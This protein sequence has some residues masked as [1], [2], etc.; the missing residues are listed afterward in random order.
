[1]RVTNDIST[2]ATGP[3]GTRNAAGRAGERE[4]SLHWLHA[5]VWG[6]VL[7]PLLVFVAACWW[8]REQSFND[9]RDTVLRA[10]RVALH[11]A[12]GALETAVAVMQRA[13]READAP[14]A[15]L[16][17]NEREI[18]QHLEDFVL[19]LPAVAA[20]T[21]WDAGGHPV[22]SS[23]VLPVHGKPSIAGRAYFIEHRT[24]YRGLVVTRRMTSLVD[25]RPYIFTS[26]RRTLA[27]GSFGGVVVVALN[28]EYFENFYR[29]LALDDPDLE[30]FS[31]F[32]ADGALLTRWPR[33]DG[34]RMPAGNAL[35]AA[36]R[37]GAR[38]GVLFTRPDG[39]AER[40]LV[41]FHRVGTEPIYVSAGLSETAFLA[42]WYRLVTLLAAVLL[43]I[44]AGLVY[45]S[46]VALRKARRE[47]SVLRQL[48]DENRL[49][50]HAEQALVQTQ[51]LE[52]LA[53]LTGGV[54]HDFNN[55]LAIINTSLHVHKR[56]HPQIGESKQIA[57]IARAVTSGARLTRQLLSFS[58]KQAIRPE[59][60]RLQQWLPA[61]ADLLRTTLGRGIELQVDVSAETP[62]VQI[63]PNEFE[64]AL[65]NIAV[66]AR[67]A[68]PEGGRFEIHAEE[69][70][71]AL[72]GSARMVA[73]HIH[74]T[75]QGIP[76]AVL[77]RVF[78]PFFTTKSPGK[79][80]GLGLSQVYGLCVQAGGMATVE[81]VAGQG[82]T[83]SLLLPAVGATAAV[84]TKT[85]IAVTTAARLHGCVLLIE[86]NGE[87][88]AGL[89]A[90][91]Q[92][93]GLS[94]R[95]AIDAEAGLAM[96][97]KDPR[98]FDLVLADITMPGPINGIELARRLQQSLPELPV[99]LMTGYSARVHEARAAGFEV[100][101][102]PT[103]PDT[104]LLALQQALARSRATL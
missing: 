91:L 13:L 94:V 57:A 65:I 86:D 32:T 8:G 9:A 87:V 62:L 50:A 36:I 53:Q 33:D 66:N 41:S 77:A 67:D 97:N 23:R 52:A 72:A 78:E 80:T 12:E 82:T 73:I 63:D 18:H 60:L 44:T 31:L 90:L 74:D 103:E 58:R 34:A 43:P 83:V 22:A 49:R 30:M 102:K 26:M 56:L 69:A 37:G 38:Q 81:S 104:L 28:P 42:D 59:T 79:G 92:L 7:I 17:A 47:Q 99:L 51:K 1:M 10:D 3:P 85:N 29:S 46:V 45:I 4:D 20:L 71:S 14:D 76:A 101:P 89:V 75:G 70:A 55:L 48:H 84:A 19:G 35:L 27:D 15:T 40:R 16:R 24:S 61:A 6:A 39:A 93:F 11:H 100:L 88:A 21:I 68:L 54:A 5:I 25:G 96:L 98:K 2:P 64:L 95:L